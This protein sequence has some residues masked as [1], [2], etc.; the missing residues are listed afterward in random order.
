RRAGER[1]RAGG[2]RRVGGRRP[3][4]PRVVSC[5][6]RKPRCRPPAPCSA[7]RA[8]ACRPHSSVLGRRAHD[9]HAFP[10]HAV[11][12]G[13]VG[14]CGAGGRAGELR[15]AGGG[16][17]RRLLRKSPLRRLLCK[18]PLRR[19]LCKSPLRRLLCKSPLRRLLHPAPL[20]RRIQ[21]ASTGRRGAGRAAAPGLAQVLA[22]LRRAGDLRGLR[23]R[24]L[25]H[26]FPPLPGILH[27]LRDVDGAGAVRPGLAGDC[28]PQAALC[29]RSHGPRHAQA[30]AVQPARHGARHGL[31]PRPQHCAWR[32]E[33]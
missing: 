22:L 16:G 33:S 13:G 32:P 21:L 8:V 30:R 15:A 23:R 26:R 7:G 12:R 2:R 9:A 31:P 27:R 17:G 19:L 24:R 3:G 11:P 25:P 18:S 5:R 14:G 6:P 10:G 20:L 4:G 28:H 1:R 29:L